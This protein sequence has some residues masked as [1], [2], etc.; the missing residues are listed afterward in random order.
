MALNAM[1]RGI[2]VRIIGDALFVASELP[3]D[4]RDLVGSAD[5]THGGEVVIPWFA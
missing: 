5:G 2:S 3:I 1:S 4:E